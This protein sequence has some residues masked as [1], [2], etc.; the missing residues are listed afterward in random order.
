MQRPRLLA[1]ASRRTATISVLFRRRLPL[2]ELEYD[3]KVQVLVLVV[4][5][6]PMENP[7]ETLVLYIESGFIRYSVCMHLIWGFA[8]PED[9][10]S[11]IL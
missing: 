6:E 1:Y 2:F 3:L 7:T 10:L 11:S 5:G 4:A 9:S 8:D